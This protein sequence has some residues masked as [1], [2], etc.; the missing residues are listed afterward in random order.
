MSTQNL[1]TDVHR[2]IFHNRQKVGTSIWPPTHAWIC[3]TR[4]IH[5]MEFHPAIKS[6]KGLILVTI[7]LTG[8][9]ADAGQPETRGSSY[10]PQWCSMIL[11]FLKVIFW[12]RSG[13]ATCSSTNKNIMFTLHH[14]IDTLVFCA[15]YYFPCLELNQKHFI[16]KHNESLITSLCIKLPVA[17]KL[18][19]NIPSYVRS[20]T[21]GYILQH[22]EIDAMIVQYWWG[23][24]ETGS[25]QDATFWFIMY[26]IVLSLF[27][28]TN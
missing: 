24:G 5:I 10:S 16:W 6:E 12:N 27:L 11:Q 23:A 2:S 4:Y 26:E 19:E 20:H 14:D 22:Y 13:F 18:Y 8:F 17:E 1:C 7:C 28:T 9:H 15:S 21:R 3:K 25:Y